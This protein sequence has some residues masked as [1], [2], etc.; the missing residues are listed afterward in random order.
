M[1]SCSREGLVRV[2]FC[3]AGIE[4]DDADFDCSV[5]D[6]FEESIAAKGL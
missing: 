2:V 3:V 4:G 1:T 5:S 6:L